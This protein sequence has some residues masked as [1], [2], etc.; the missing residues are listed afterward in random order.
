M[1]RRPLPTTGIRQRCFAGSVDTEANAQT[2][3]VTLNNAR[4]EVIWMGRPTGRRASSRPTRPALY[5]LGGAAK[6]DPVQLGQPRPRSEHA[7]HAL[8]GA[9]PALGHDA[10]PHHDQGG[11]RQRAHAVGISSSGAPTS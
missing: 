6:L 10:D 7:R 11:A 5:A 1:S 8:D 9:V 4:A 3:A 2:I